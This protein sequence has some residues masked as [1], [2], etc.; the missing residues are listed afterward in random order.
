M[1]A[2]TAVDRI[3]SLIRA[4]LAASSALSITDDDGNVIAPNILDRDE[5]PAVLADS[6]QGLPAICVVPIGDKPDT[7]HPYIGSADWEHRFSVMIAGYY[8]APSNETQGEDIYSNIAFLRQKAYDCADL[9]RFQG[10][11][12]QPG[13]VYDIKVELGYFEIV[14]YVIYKF[15]VTLAITIFEV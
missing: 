12:F 4:R 11:F 5:N 15:V 1:T 7:I 6:P 8:R 14:D 3:A 9:F 10:A 13:N 2:F